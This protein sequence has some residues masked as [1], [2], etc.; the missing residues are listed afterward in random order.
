[1][2]KT[3]HKAGIL[4]IFLCHQS[5]PAFSQTLSWGNS[6][7]PA[8]TNGNTNGNATNVGG[9]GVN[10]A[11]A[12]NLSGGAF[13]A[14]S[15]NATPSVLG[16]NVVVAGSASRLNLSPNFGSNTEYANTVISFSKLTSHISFRI[17]DID[18]QNGNSNSYY[19]RVT[20]T[21]TDG[22]TTFYPTLTK[23]DA[24]TDPDFLL[25]SGNSAYANTTNGKGGKTNSNAGDQRG[26]IN[27]DF[28]TALLLTVTIRF[29]NAPGAQANPATQTIALGE[30]AFIQPALPVKFLSFSGAQNNHHISLQWATAQEMN[31]EKF[32]VQ[33][34]MPGT[35]WETIATVSAAGFSSMPTDYSYVD[36]TAI[37]TTLLYRLKQ[38][39][40]DGKYDYSTVIRIDNK[41]T[42]TAMSCYP[43]PFVNTINI[44]VYSPL[45]QSTRLVIADLTGRK[46]FSTVNLLSR[47]NNNFSVIGLD[48]LLPG[49]YVLSLSDQ[50]HRCLGYFRLLKK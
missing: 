35:N 38:I 47:G 9:Q 43:N 1:M 17:A 4:L 32:E 27:V 7:S 28:G 8:W 21:G 23:Y 20:I 13:A 45:D 34:S 39:D 37:A 41:A 33:R 22:T 15:G 12:V 19:D 30:M 46:V 18:K 16:S 24:T 31:S 11:T 6:F 40:Y 48:K 42:A 44:S 10:I 3:L 26:T 5:L 25:I 29:D 49:I 14:S 36:A 50:E 2:R